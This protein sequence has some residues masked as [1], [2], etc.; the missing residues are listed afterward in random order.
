MKTKGGGV[1]E[2]HGDGDMNQSRLAHWGLG[3]E[4]LI[5]K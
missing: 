5:I 2:K 3:A 4:G 1:I